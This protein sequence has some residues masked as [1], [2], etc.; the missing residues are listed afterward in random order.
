MSNQVRSDVRP[1]D[2]DDQV[3]QLEL[4]VARRRER[5]TSTLTNLRSEIQEAQD[6]RHWYERYPLVFLGGAALAGWMAGQIL[7]PRRS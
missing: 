4:E 6:W 1:V 5:L 3:R 7:F 2:I